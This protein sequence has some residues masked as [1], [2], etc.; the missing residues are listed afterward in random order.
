MY[1]NI[2]VTR[3]S[4]NTFTIS[5]PNGTYILSPSKYQGNKDYA[6]YYFARLK[7]EYEY[8]SGMYKIEERNRVY[9][10][11]TYKGQ[12]LIIDVSKS[13]LTHRPKYEEVSSQLSR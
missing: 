10:Q 5:T 3:K 12:A 6:P 7:P 8:I 9:Y 4:N 11:G 1:Q 13:I 2:E